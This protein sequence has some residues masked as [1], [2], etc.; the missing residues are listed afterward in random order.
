MSKKILSVNYKGQDFPV[1]EL[2]DRPD[3]YGHDQVVVRFVHQ[4]GVRWTLH[5]K[6]NEILLT[7][8]SPG[9]W[10][11]WSELRIQTARILGYDNPEKHGH[12]SV[13]NK[14]MKV[15]NLNGYHMGGQRIYFK[16][17]KR[18]NKYLKNATML[19]SSSK[20]S[21][22]IDMILS[23]PDYTYNSNSPHI[24]T[25]LGELFFELKEDR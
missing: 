25:S 15:G 11:T 4:V 18:D 21:A 19:G 23:T 10:S 12:Y 24:I 16:P 13:H 17:N 9:S 22:M 5:K 1:I 3:R 8:S 20:D 7:A 14:L 2:D 6:D